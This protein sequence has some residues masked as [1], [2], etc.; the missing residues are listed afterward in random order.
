[1]GE[2]EFSFNGRIQ[3]KHQLVYLVYENFV[4]VHGR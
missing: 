3:F 1:M 4:L 2:Y